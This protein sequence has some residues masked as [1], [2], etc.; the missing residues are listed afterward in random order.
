MIKVYDKIPSYRIISLQ[1]LPLNSK[2]SSSQ[3]F[4]S[5]SLVIIS[6]V[7]RIRFRGVRLWGSEFGEN[8]RDRESD[9]SLA[10][11]RKEAFD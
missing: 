4:G 11:L 1:T 6:Y 7:T 2:I 10:G 8:C 5:L 3:T 9:L